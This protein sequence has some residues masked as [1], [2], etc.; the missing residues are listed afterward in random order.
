[1]GNL[2]QARVRLLLVSVLRQ[3]VQHQGLEGDPHA[4]AGQYLKGGKESI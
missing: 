3:G 1:M 2:Q 4:A